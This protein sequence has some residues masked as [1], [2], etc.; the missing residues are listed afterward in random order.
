MFILGAGV[1]VF[2][3]G[4]SAMLEGIFWHLYVYLFAL[5]FGLIGFVDDYRKVRQH[6][7]EGPDCPAEV[8]PADALSQSVPGAD[9]L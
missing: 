3:L 6:Q 9:A 5:I 1:T 7:N 4:W 2:V 8:H